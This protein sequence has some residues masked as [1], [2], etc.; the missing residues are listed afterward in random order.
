MLLINDKPKINYS[1]QMHGELDVS[2]AMFFHVNLSDG[3][4]YKSSRRCAKCLIS[5]FEINLLPLIEV[6]NKQ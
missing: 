4:E 1:C 3:T 5:L 6:E 2:E